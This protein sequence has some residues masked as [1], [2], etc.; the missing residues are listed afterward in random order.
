VGGDALTSIEDYLEHFTSRGRMPT[1]DLLD[2]NAEDP[3]KALEWAS[4]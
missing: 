4:S 2:L 1:D 3:A